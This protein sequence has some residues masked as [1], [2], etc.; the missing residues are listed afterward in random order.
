M[1]TFVRTNERVNEQKEKEVD[2]VKVVPKGLMVGRACCIH[3]C[4]WNSLNIVIEHHVQ[5]NNI[6][7][8]LIHFKRC[9]KLRALLLFI[10]TYV[11]DMSCDG[12]QEIDFCRKR[13]SS[14]WKLKERCLPFSHSTQGVRISVSWPICIAHFLPQ[15]LCFFSSWAANVILHTFWVPFYRAYWVLSCWF[16]CYRT[17]IDRV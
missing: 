11:S 12:T 15:S 16:C 1:S 5:L 13:K 8:T 9:Q 7:R 2:T 17:C 3:M 6:L 14:K 4:M 10:Y